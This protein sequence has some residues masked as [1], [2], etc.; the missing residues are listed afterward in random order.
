METI[1]EKEDNL[2]ATAFYDY[3]EILRKYNIPF[4]RQEEYL[5]VIRS[6]IA[7]GWVLYISIVKSQ[8]VELLDQLIPFLENQH[9]SYSLPENS[10]IHAWILDGSFGYQ[11]LAKVIT[12][13]PGISPVSEIAKGLIEIAG[14][15]DGPVIPMAIPLSGNVFTTF[16]TSDPTRNG[17]GLTDK[18]DWPF[19]AIAKKNK[20]PTQSRWLKRKYFIVQILKADVKGNVY[21]AFK[22]DNPFAIC[23]CVIKE[24]KKYQCAD[25]Y[26][27]DIKDRI[28]WQY[29]CH[30]ELSSLLLL[31][32]PLDLFE[33]NGNIYFV[34]EFIEGT[35][36]NDAISEIQEGII[37]HCLPAK[38]QML[39]IDILLKLVEAI[40]NLHLRGFVHRDLNPVNF[41]INRLGYP[42]AIDI[43]LAYDLENLLPTPAFAQGTPG[44]MSLNQSFLKTPVYGDDIFGLGGLMIR[45]VTGLS[46][47]KFSS[48]TT[49]TLFDRLNY[50][51]R[52][53][54]LANMI[55]CCRNDSD[56]QRPSLKSIKHNLELYHS[57]IMTNNQIDE[58]KK[59]IID[60]NAII[61]AGLK[62]LINSSFGESRIWLSKFEHE[63]KQVS[64]TS[65]LK[66]WYP[67]IYTGN[68]G[69]LHLLIKAENLGFNIDQQEVLFKNFDYL[70]GYYNADGEKDPGLFTGAA[71]FA[72][73][74]ANMIRV[75]LLEKSI[76]NYDRISHLLAFPNTKL[77][78]FDGIAGEGLAIIKCAE[79]LSFPRFL[80]NISELTS[81][82]LDKQNKDGSWY[83]TTGDN[84][85]QRVKVVGLL[86]GVSGILY[87]LLCASQNINCSKLNLGIAKGLAW[88]S[89]QSYRV[90]NENISW[91]VSSTVQG[92]DPWIE[93]GFTG[94]AL[95][96]IKAYELKKDVVY[97]EIVYKTLLRHPKKLTSNYLSHATGISGLLE[98]YIEASKVFDDPEWMERAE[99]VVTFLANVSCS[100][101]SGTYWLD[102]NEVELRP[103]FMTGNSGILHALLR[104]QYPSKLSFPIL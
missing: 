100:D 36:F 42:V 27:R 38:K 50:F 103:D 57:Q 77:N 88:L 28:I 68:T 15:F 97:K 89:N 79:L 74:L 83:L 31:P 16:E 9:L 65:K 81:R 47:L 61:T 48:D 63:V 95:L 4:S 20:M 96:Y 67:G 52:N 40:E 19:K 78:L 45:T 70:S 73:L 37:W 49:T 98:V 85:N 13:F 34:M 3:K 93:N 43:E 5:T 59:S 22:L 33:I 80:T 11:K 17:K 86:H 54:R 92:E 46:P 99:Q 55:A 60:L 71:G 44:Y 29:R 14:Y 64:N 21:K 8:M 101:A 12:I 90:N 24:G 62:K 66:S 56:D 32:K 102:G 26:D 25:R 84:S 58:E 75:N 1:I 82:I 39:L 41:I 91:R 18:E 30:T 94:I 2:K 51:I 6:D 72:L 23:W 69:I 87:F 104:Y 10:N 7:E 53:R 35:S 76:T